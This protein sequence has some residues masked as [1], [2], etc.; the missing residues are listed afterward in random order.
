[1]TTSL[2]TTEREKALRRDVLKGT[3][4]G[5]GN[6]GW[7]VKLGTKEWGRLSMSELKA[8]G[9]QVIPRSQNRIS[10]RKTLKRSL[11]T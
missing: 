6:G 9:E 2:G 11:E 7:P 5:G 3:C 10:N 1:M 4:I 8:L